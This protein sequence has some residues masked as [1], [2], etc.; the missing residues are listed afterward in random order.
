MNRRMLVC[1][2]WHPKTRLL[3]LVVGGLLA[4]CDSNGQQ[5]PEL[6]FPDSLADARWQYSLTK[7]ATPQEFPNAAFLSYL[8]H[9]ARTPEE[10]F[11][12][13]PLHK[14]RT[15]APYLWTQYGYARRL[16]LFQEDT[17]AF[18]RPA[19]GQLQFSDDSLR[20]RVQVLESSPEALLAAI[21]TL[22]LH[23]APC[24]HRALLLLRYDYTEWSD[25]TD[26]Y[27]PDR[28][29]EEFFPENAVPQAADRDV[30]RFGDVALALEEEGIRQQLPCYYTH[31]PQQTFGR[32]G[33]ESKTIF[34]RW[35]DGR[36]VADEN[37]GIGYGAPPAR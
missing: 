14:F 17:A 37:A 32:A 8:R 29:P 6:N 4:G 33:T 13:F 5:H 20:V 22:E 9:T 12:I 34:Y 16:R 7:L 3:V 21:E 27:L 35:Q 28:L 11:V 19:P 25:V 24:P 1:W 23:A 26:Q 31:K 15:A 10:V 30:L 18:T 2:P 36:Y